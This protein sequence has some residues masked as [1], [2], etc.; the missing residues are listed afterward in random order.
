MVGVIGELLFG[1]DQDIA[2][3]IR[4]RVCDMEVELVQ[5]SQGTIGNLLFRCGGTKL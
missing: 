3:R 5:A 1:Q 4:E 2:V